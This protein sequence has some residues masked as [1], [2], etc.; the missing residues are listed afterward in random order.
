MFCPRC[1]REAIEKG[2]FCAG[3]GASLAV[4]PPAKKKMLGLIGGIL[5]I[6]A[7]GIVVLIAGFIFVGMGLAAT[8]EDGPPVL[9]LLLPLALLAVG[10]LGIAGGIC[11]VKRRKWGLALAGAIAVALPASE[12]GIAALVLVA[13]ARDEFEQGAPAVAAERVQP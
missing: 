8:A 5:E 4:A 3:C 10:A 9:L 6:V 12:L 1:G 7:G 13:L 11:A 2:L